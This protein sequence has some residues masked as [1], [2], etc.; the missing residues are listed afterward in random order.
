L[1]AARQPSRPGIAKAKFD[2]LNKEQRVLANWQ[3][4]RITRTELIE[5]YKKDARRRPL[6]GLT[7]RADD[8]TG[9]TCVIIEGPNTTWCQ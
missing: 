4:L 6:S 8:A 5:G 3:C 7:A 9:R 2:R 1:P